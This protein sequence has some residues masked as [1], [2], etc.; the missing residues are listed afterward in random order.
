[1]LAVN[2]LSGTSGEEGSITC[3]L[4]GRME[5]SDGLFP[6]KAR[7]MVARSTDNQRIS[8]DGNA[9][10]CPDAF[11]PLLSGALDGTVSDPNIVHA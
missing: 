1:M 4:P 10:M 3:T 2:K 11:P 9:L 7:P 5:R 6:R 8:W